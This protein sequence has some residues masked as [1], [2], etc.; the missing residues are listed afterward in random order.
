MYWEDIYIWPKGD[1]WLLLYPSYFCIYYCSIPDCIYLA[2]T[3]ISFYFVVTCIWFSYFSLSFH[4]YQPLQFLHYFFT[5]HFVML[6]I[7]HSYFVHFLY[8]LMFL[9]DFYMAYYLSRIPDE[10][11]ASCCFYYFFFIQV[12]GYFLFW[13]KSV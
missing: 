5:Y 12:N 2:F 6:G 1:H 13:G 7:W 11:H 10:R 3:C 8:V 4:L 9:P